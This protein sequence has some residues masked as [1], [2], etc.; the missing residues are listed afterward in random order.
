MLLPLST[1]GIQ[2]FTQVKHLSNAVFAD[3]ETNINDWIVANIDAD[4]DNYYSLDV[5]YF[6]DDTNY[7][8]S[9][10]YTRY[11]VDPEFAPAEA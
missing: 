9:I 11:V 4:T 2:T 7:N 8:A 3:L 10:Q 6:W 5:K 1:S